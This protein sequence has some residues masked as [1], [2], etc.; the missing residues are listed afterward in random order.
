MIASILH[1]TD[2]IKRPEAYD[3]DVFTKEEKVKVRT[4]IQDDRQKPILIISDT[5]KSFEINQQLSV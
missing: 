3:E 5:I 4:Y 1:H 2:K